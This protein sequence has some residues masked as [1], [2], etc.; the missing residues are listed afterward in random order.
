MTSWKCLWDFQLRDETTDEE[1]DAEDDEEM[2]VD[3]RIVLAIQS[4]NDPPSFEKT[5]SNEYKKMVFLAIK[6]GR[7][8]QAQQGDGK[9]QNEYNF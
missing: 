6:Y 1:E 4:M 7:L 2:H 9:D 5:I 3:E 8:L